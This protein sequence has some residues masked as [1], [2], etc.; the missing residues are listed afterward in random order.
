[1]GQRRLEYNVPAGMIELASIDTWEFNPFE[2][3]LFDSGAP[4][5]LSAMDALYILKGEMRRYQEGKRKRI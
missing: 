3:R 1:M 4:L 2:Q 5:R